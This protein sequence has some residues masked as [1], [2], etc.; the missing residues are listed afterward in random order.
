M[1]LSL[2]LQTF[3]TFSSRFSV[4]FCLFFINKRLD[5]CRDLSQALTNHAFVF[6]CLDDFRLVSFE[7]IDILS[8]M[9][10]LK[11]HI[12]TFRTSYASSGLHRGLRFTSKYCK[13]QEKFEFHQ[14][15]E[16]IALES[17]HFYVFLQ[18]TLTP[19]LKYRQI[20]LFLVSLT[21]ENQRYST[22]SFFLCLLFAGQQLYLENLL[23]LL[24]IS[25]LYFY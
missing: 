9:Q 8:S 22:K 23:L 14:F 6:S 25:T 16:I 11:W 20:C 15:N 4:Y 10:P 21:T 7:R 5:V 17:A 1:S 3:F 18:D 19:V 12:S 13:N 2:S 24:G